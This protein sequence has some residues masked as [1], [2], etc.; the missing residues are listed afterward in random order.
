VRCGTGDE[1]GLL[2]T[3]WTNHHAAVERQIGELGGSTFTAQLLP[4]VC[5]CNNRDIVH[6]ENNLQCQ[7]SLGSCYYYYYY[8][9]RRVLQHYIQFPWWVFH[10]E[11]ASTRLQSF[12]NLLS[13]Y[14][15][16]CLGHTL[17]LLT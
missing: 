16:N 9:S 12:E 13:L 6:D 10:G 7:D 4:Y 3:G 17:A 14:T 5:V 11:I 2:R 8:K 15:M 1:S